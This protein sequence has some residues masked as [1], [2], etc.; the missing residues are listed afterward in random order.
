MGVFLLCTMGCEVDPGC[1]VVSED[2]TLLFSKTAG[3]GFVLTKG[4]NPRIGSNDGESTCLG[5]G[6][7]F[8]MVGGKL[9]ST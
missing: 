8:E 7:D 2:G 3:L 6:D 1:K 5:L 4:G 9:P